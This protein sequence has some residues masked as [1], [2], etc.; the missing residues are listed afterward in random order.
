MF[1]IDKILGIK[2][3]GTSWHPLPG[4]SFSVPRG[5]KIAEKWSM[6]PDNI[7]ILI[8]HT[9][10]L[11][12]NDIFRDGTKWGCGDLLNAIEKRIKPKVHVF[13]HVHENNGITSNDETYFINASICSHKLECKNKS[14]VFD[15]NIKEHN[16]CQKHVEYKSQE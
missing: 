16:V 9:P 6:I 10:P 12:H 4:Y 3:Y 2:I 1:I 13:G 5:R 14:I 11:G 15:W 8:T 7:D